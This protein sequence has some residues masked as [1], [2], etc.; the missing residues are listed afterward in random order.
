MFYILFYA[1][2]T[3]ICAV[4]RIE[5]LPVQRGTIYNA[6]WKVCWICMY[7]CVCLCKVMGVLVC[8]WAYVY[9]CA[10]ACVGIYLSVHLIEEHKPI[11]ISTLQGKKERMNQPN[12]LIACAVSLT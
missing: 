12:V 3:Y 6:E 11:D 8:A 9:V 10:C 5:N 4:Q 2:L 1:W 7:L